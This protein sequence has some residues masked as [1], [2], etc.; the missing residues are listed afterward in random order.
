MLCNQGYRQ[1]RQARQAR[2][3]R[4][5]TRNR[6]INIQVFCTTFNQIHL[7]MYLENIQVI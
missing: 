1:A 6:L 2:K 7:Y 5:K 4:D 3:E